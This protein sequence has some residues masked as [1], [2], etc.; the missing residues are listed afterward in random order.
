[1]SSLAFADPPD[2]PL[3]EALVGWLL[4]PADA[5]L[6]GDEPV[7]EHL[8][9]CDR[10]TA[11]VDGLRAV[12]AALAELQRHSHDPIQTR[13]GVAAL[14]RRGERVQHFFGG[15]G[16]R[17]EGTIARESDIVIMHLPVPLTAT[18][19]LTVTLCD[20]DGQ[21]FFE[22]VSAGARDPGEVLLACHRAIADGNPVLRV[23]VRDEAAALLC[24][25]VFAQR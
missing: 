19:P 14:E 9:G 25:A 5:D 15:D 12:T 24:D 2:H 11:R 23:Q 1:M 3:D 16:V 22:I 6:D 4:E 20:P 8:F 7:A 13:A 21:P 17:I 18:G 10:C